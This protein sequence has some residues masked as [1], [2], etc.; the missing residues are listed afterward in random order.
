MNKICLAAFASL[1]SATQLLE[2]SFL[3]SEEPTRQYSDFGSTSCQFVVDGSWYS[4]VETGDLT[5]PQFFSASNTLATATAEFTYCQ[6]LSNTAAPLC[7]SSY[8]ASVYDESTATCNLNSDS[9][10][11]SLNSDSNLVLQYSNTD[12]S[13]NGGVSALNVAQVCD[14]NAVNPTTG[15][16][17]TN[18]GGATY[19]TS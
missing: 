11:L 6:N 2:P 9:V 17:T 3:Q 18:D 12:T 19:H 15:D 13:T 5:T 16:L 4:F 14:E 10:S 8:F 1:A 7:S